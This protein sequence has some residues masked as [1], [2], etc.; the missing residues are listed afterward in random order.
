MKI[1]IYPGSFAPITKG[2]M[3]IILRASKLVD[4]LIIALLYNPAKTDMQFSV[5]DRLHMMHLATSDIGNVIVDS[6]SG[7]LVEYI[8]NKNIDLIIKGIRN[9]TDFEYEA[10]MAV[11]NKKLHGNIETIFLLS[12][13][14][15][16][17]L[18]S[19]VVR[20]LI[21]FGGNIEE[22]V[23]KQIITTLHSLQKY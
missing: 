9:S 18:S 15:Y 19:S 12:S 22:F 20:E 5:E 21:H 8:Q 3:D 14:E 2:H 17:L 11:I 10:Q 16:T 23:P 1:G 13:P 7:L 4:K 6:H